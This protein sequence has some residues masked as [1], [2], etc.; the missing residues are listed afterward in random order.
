VAVTR[1]PRR[2]L[3]MLSFLLLLEIFTPIGSNGGKCPEQVGKE[4]PRKR[5]SAQVR[6]EWKGK[7]KGESVELRSPLIALPI[8][9]KK[10]ASLSRMG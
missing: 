1:K 8:L 9:I 4:P 5:S 10:G 7:G 6:Y 3:H 2:S